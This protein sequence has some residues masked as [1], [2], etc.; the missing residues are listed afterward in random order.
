[1]RDRNVFK[2]DV[3]Q[4]RVTSNIY[5][6]YIRH[7]M[8][9]TEIL[10]IHSHPR[11]LDTDGDGIL[12]YEHKEGAVENWADV[13]GGS[14][15]YDPGFGYD[16]PPVLELGNN[17]EHLDFDTYIQYTSM[18]SNDFRI[19]NILG[20]IGVPAF[21]PFR[22][23][24]ADGIYNICE[25]NHMGLEGN[26]AP[27]FN[28]RKCLEIMKEMFEDDIP[29]MFSYFTFDGENN[30]KSLYRQFEM[31]DGKIK[32]DSPVASHY[33]TATG[34]VEYSEDVKEILGFQRAIKVATWGQQFYMNYDDIGNHLD[35]FTNI[36]E[37]Y[38]VGE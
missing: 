34:I 18:V 35:L 16:L 6:D 10:P 25:R 23:T 7:I 21:G 8:A 29:V 26:W 17:F 32:E 38:R 3:T 12:D 37:L 31:E 36:Y 30:S 19:E 28:S 15:P 33:M 22:A 4:Y 24:L 5:E 13:N 1:M 11:R 14:L 27:A 9:N 2:R 20:E